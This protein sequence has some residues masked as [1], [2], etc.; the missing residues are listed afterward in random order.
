M[1]SN[2]NDLQKLEATKEVFISEDQAF[3]APAKEFVPGPYYKNIEEVMPELTEQAAKTEK[4]AKKLPVDRRD[5]MRLFGASAVMASTACVRRPVERAVPYVNQPTDQVPGLPVYYATTLDGHGVIVKTREGRPVMIEGNPE[6]PLSQGSCSSFAISELQAL[7]HPDR[8]KNPQVLFGNNRRDDATWDEVYSRMA[9]ELKGSKKVA[10][11]AKETTGN[12]KKFYKEFLEKIGSSENNLY[13]YDTNALRNAQAAAY[14]MAFNVDGVA[15]TN[16]NAA[17]Y[18]A[19]VGADFLD[20]GTAHIYESKSWTKSQS[21]HEDQK[22]K[23]VQFESRLTNTGSKA[24]ERH[25][26]GSGDELAITLA[27]VEALMSNPNSVGTSSEKAEIQKVLSANSGLIASTKKRLHLDDK[28]FSEIAKDLINKPSIVMAGESGASSENATMIQLA[29]IMANILCGAFKEKL[30]AL[31]RAW[32]TSSAGSGDITRFLND[33]EDIDFLFVIDVNPAFT[34]PTSSN[35][36][37]KLEKI[38][39]VASVQ[40]M[41]CETDKYANFVLNANHTLESWGDEELI[42]GFWSMVQP[43]VRPFT[44][45]MQAEDILLWTAAKLGKPMGYREYREYVR[46]QWKKLHKTRGIKHDFDVFFK[47]VQRKGTYG[48]FKTRSVG[49]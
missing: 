37:E 8:R 17:K 14:K 33:A 27:I 26:I 49:K 45:S 28:V 16:L 2:D 40:S 6:H 34:L 24:D 7:F 4:A 44:N 12:T 22:G 29:A 5:F 9:A 43:T 46:A 11:L 21:F 18:I 38:K 15:R 41:P 10:I 36:R 47:A 23:M 30:L 31:D 20:V 13:L 32:M 3:E 35:V 42:S 1:R 48:R 19:G 25:V 39:N